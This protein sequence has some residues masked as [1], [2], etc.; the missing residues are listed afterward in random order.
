VPLHEVEFHT[1]VADRVEFACRLLRKAYRKGVR[2]V[3]TAPAPVLATL[4]RQLWT[5]EER[6]FVPHVRVTVG[7]PTALLQRTPIWLVE[8]DAP[9]GAPG[10]LVNLGA[11]APADLLPFERVIEIVSRES[12]DEQGGRRRWRDY[13]SRGLEVRHHP[14]G[15]DPAP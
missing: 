7:T 3:V 6:D 13:K 11:E 4:D 2:V 12:E 14:A 8:G 9:P 15:N 1:G 5:F 10:V